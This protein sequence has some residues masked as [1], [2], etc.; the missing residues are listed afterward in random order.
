MESANT[1]YQQV[2]P[3]GVED[4]APVLVRVND[5]HWVSLSCCAEIGVAVNE[6][7]AGALVTAML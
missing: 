7:V 1:N 3:A 2:L 5:A 6:Y 4:F